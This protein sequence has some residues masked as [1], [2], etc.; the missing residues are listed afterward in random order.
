M[1]KA[2][3]IADSIISNVKRANDLYSKTKK[4]LSKLEAEIMDIEHF[5]E[6]GDFNVIQGYY[7]AKSIQKLRNK[8]RELKNQRETLEILVNALNKTVNIGFI[9]SISSKIQSESD[10]LEY[11]KQNKLYNPRIL[12]SWDKQFLK[13]YCNSIEEEV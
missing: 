3:A 6:M 10:Q 11:S 13:Q 4:D 9:K 2:Q 8:R 7:Y 1:C 5:I 12:K